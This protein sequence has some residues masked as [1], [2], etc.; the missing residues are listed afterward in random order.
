[1]LQMALP[2]MEAKISV[3][4]SRFSLLFSLGDQRSL[5]STKEAPKA[6]QLHT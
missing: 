5:G 1:M 4:H 2:H 3:S 6:Q